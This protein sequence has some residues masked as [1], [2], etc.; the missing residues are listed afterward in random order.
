M[1]KHDKLSSASSTLLARRG[2]HAQCGHNSN[3]IRRRRIAV[4]NAIYWN[5]K[6]PT[7][8][9]F[10][11]S[12]HIAAERRSFIHLHNT[13]TTQQSVVFYSYVSPA[14]VIRPHTT[15]VQYVLYYSLFCIL[16]F[17]HTST[18]CH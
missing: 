10:L 17:I 13:Q 12:F 16:S 18:D 9:R 3:H 6:S 11:H 4:Q 1:Q 14:I 8:S 2:S 7:C 5:R 15:K